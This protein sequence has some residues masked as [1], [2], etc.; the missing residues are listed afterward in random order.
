MFV[1]DPA[2]LLPVLS[3]IDESERVGLDTETTGLNPHRDRVRLLQ[4]ATDR[5]VYVL[6]LF[7]LGD[8]SALWE[9]L[10]GVE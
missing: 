3:S 8:L 1:T 5:G 6:D 9:A 2:E 4:L 10:S 7:V